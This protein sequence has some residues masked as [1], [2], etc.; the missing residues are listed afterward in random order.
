MPRVLPVHEQLYPNKIMPRRLEE[1]VFDD[2]RPPTINRAYAKIVTGSQV[3]AEVI[4]AQASL[5]LSN[6]DPRYYVGTCFHEAG[7]ENEWDTEIA[8]ASCPTGF[9]SV[10]AYQIG[11]EEARRFGFSLADMLNL[12]KAT[13]CM[14]KLAEANRTQLRLY[15]KLAPGAP[16]P[17]YTDPHGVVWPGGTMRAYLAIAHNHG[18]GYARSTIARYGMNWAA[19]KT[20]NPTDRIVSNN[21]GE[22]CVTGG[23][24]YPA[25]PPGPK[26]GERTLLLKDPRMTG[27][28]VVEMQRHLKITPDGV[29]GIMTDTAVRMFQRAKGLTVDGICGPKTW[30]A[31]LAT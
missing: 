2:G 29:F 11:E 27:P 23:A 15:A 21:Y 16:D 20:R 28:D 13:Q 31:L 8:T 12:T 7:C 9:Q 3:Y 4:S 1:Y 6:I 26:P 5:A 30:T 24:Q 17:D 22:D 25:T 10:G 19:Y 18:T 14:V